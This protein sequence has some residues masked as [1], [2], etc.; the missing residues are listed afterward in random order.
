MKR[1]LN[2]FWWVVGVVI[3]S[4]IVIVSMWNMPDYG[5]AGKVKN[6]MLK[7]LLSED[8]P[9]I[10]IANAAAK[11][12]R[13]TFLDSRSREE[14]N[15][16]HIRNAVYVGYKDFELSRVSP[17]PKD[18]EIIVYCSVGKRSDEVTKKLQDAGYANVHNLYGG[19]FEW[20]NKGYEIVNTS[21]QPTDT[22]HAYSKLFSWWLDRGEKV[23]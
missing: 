14:Y 16:S 12:G 6:A 22:I 18:Q 20:F 11:K 15:V 17:V 10:S 9:K 5:I 8:V 3:V 19:I 7:V 2:I 13:A 23:Y 1:K 4:I 21:N